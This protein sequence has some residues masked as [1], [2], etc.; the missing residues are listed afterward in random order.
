M[1]KNEV[2]QSEISLPGFHPNL[3][4]ML[5]ENAAKFT[6]H[7]IYQEVR[8]GKYTPLTWRQFQTDVISIQNTLENMG[9]FP[10]DHVAF[11]SRNRQEMLEM[12]LNELFTDVIMGM[13][14]VADDIGL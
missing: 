10:G 14:D 13:R 2:Y 12:E 7:P 9:L 3:A 8:T 1:T 11:L 5:N 4:S 6:D